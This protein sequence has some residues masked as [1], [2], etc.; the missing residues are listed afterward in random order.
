MTESVKN[1]ASALGLNEKQISTDIE[2]FLGAQGED[3]CL[4]ALNIAS[5]ASE[6]TD[7]EGLH[8]GSAIKLWRWASRKVVADKHLAQGQ[9][10]SEEERKAL[11][12]AYDET[13]KKGY[14]P[15]KETLLAQIEGMY[16]D[17]EISIQ[18]YNWGM[19]GL[20]TVYG[21]VAAAQADDSDV[22]F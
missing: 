19:A 13:K 6:K 9:Q 7:K 5:K 22:P 20:S 16:D 1:T 18:E 3:I 15:N 8:G 14:V 11:Q 12:D 4:H 2:A 21:Y 17:G 10:E